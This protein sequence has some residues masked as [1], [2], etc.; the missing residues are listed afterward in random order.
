MAAELLRHERHTLRLGGVQQ[1]P[2]LA[3]LAVA[4]PVR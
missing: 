2:A 1:V 4:A 3:V